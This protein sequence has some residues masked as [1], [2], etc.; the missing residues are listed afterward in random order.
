MKRFVTVAVRGGYLVAYIRPDGT[1]CA[2]SDHATIDTAK[3]WA[4]YNQAEE[5]KRCQREALR[6]IAADTI[7][8]PVRYFEPD[9][10][11]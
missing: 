2:V 4:Q 6:A 7:R 9:A 11:A 5:L 3:K 8:R 10:F 1:L